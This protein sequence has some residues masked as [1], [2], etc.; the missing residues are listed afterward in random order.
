MSHGSSVR[1]SVSVLGLVL[2]LLPAPA[3]AKSCWIEAMMDQAMV[4]SISDLIFVG[5]AVA[6]SVEIFEHIEQPGYEH[7]SA[8]KTT[9]IIE[10][11]K[12][13][14]INV[15]EKLSVEKIGDC[16]CPGRFS[17][18]KKYLVHTQLVGADK[19]PALYFCSF[20]KLIN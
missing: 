14:E 8:E 11:V 20:N 6:R 18:G 10:T 3:L 17:V 19:K 15:G 16:S 1:I 13:G 12:K 7:I 5:T 9:F 2:S 4:E